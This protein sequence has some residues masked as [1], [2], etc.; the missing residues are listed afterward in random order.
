MYF[1]KESVNVRGPRVD[2]MNCKSM[3][4]ALMSSVFFEEYQLSK[5]GAKEFFQENEAMYVSTLTETYRL[6]GPVDG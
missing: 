3:F 1:G 4:D 5:P 6:L 2:V